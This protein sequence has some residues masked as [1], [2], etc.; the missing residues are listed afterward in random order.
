[1]PCY[2]QSIS[3]S[4]NKI[5]Q[6]QKFSK[7]FFL[8]K[9]YKLKSNNLTVQIHVIYVSGSRHTLKPEGMNI[10]TL[11]QFSIQEQFFKLHERFSR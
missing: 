7:H 8:T 5:I 4:S 9:T 6:E 10:F 3:E 1:M 11:Q 2:P